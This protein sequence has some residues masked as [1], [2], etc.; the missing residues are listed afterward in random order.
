MKTNV[1]LVFFRSNRAHRVV[2]QVAITGQEAPSTDKRLREDLF[3]K[4][5]SGDPVGARLPYAAILTKM[6]TFSGF[7]MNET[8]KFHTVTE[9]T[10]PSTMRRSL[11]IICAGRF[12]G[13]Q[14]LASV[15]RGTQGYFLMQE[16]VKDL[17]TS[18]PAAGALFTIVFGDLCDFS[19]ATF[20]QK[21]ERCAEGGGDGGL[22]RA[23]MRAA[24]GLP[25][26]GRGPPP[27]RR[28][29][30]GRPSAR[31]GRG[32][33]RGGGRYL[34]GCWATY[35]VNK[36]HQEVWPRVPAR[37]RVGTLRQ[38]K[39]RGWWKELPRR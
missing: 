22:T 35:H 18:Q 7:G 9:M 37:D 20:R 28:R 16:D 26:G 32:G 34:V 38:L 1:V 24:C 27:R 13:A 31:R 21:I 25:A 36:L 15:P 12:V 8:L 17:V 5:M 33:D 19:F 4:V 30:R 29:S 11:I 6:V 10:F 39:A 2:A 23:T 3:T 14:R